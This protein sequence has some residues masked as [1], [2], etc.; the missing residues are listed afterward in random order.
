MFI[1]ASAMKSTIFFLEIKEEWK[2]FCVEL[3]LGSIVAQIG[4]NILMRHMGNVFIVIICF[5][6]F[7]VINFE[8]NLS[9]SY[10]VVF[11]HHQKNRNKNLNILENEEKHFHQF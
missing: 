1:K 10:Q 11:L 8:I 2:A 6:G 9:F 4:T 7:D 3:V 5:L